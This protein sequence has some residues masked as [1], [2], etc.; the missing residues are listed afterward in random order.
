MAA[1]RPA[2]RT[3]RRPAFRAR[4]ADPNL[5]ALGSLEDILSLS[6]DAGMEVFELAERLVTGAIANRQPVVPPELVRLCSDLK[7]LER[8][9]TAMWAGGADYVWEQRSELPLDGTR[10][11]LV[12]NGSVD[13]LEYLSRVESVGEKFE[14]T[15]ASA[16]GADGTMTMATAFT[17]IDESCIDAAMDELP[18]IAQRMLSNARGYLES[19]S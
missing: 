14:G 12:A 16:G 17:Q 2:R 5:P 13:V 6:P 1:V 18:R 10:E 19:A 11:L 15:S 7:L 4:L 9:H 8:L 3:A